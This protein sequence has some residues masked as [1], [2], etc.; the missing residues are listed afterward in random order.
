MRRTEDIAAA[1]ES[2]DGRVEAVYIVGD[3]FASANRLRIS[4]FALAARLPT[5]CVQRDYIEVGGLL[6]Y[7]PNFPDLCRRAAGYAERSCV[8][9]NPPTCRSNSQPNSTWSST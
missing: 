7:G 6:S 2:F 1:F 4:T 8:G 5:V 3:A 9:P